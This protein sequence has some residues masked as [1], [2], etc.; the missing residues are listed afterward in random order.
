MM[1]QCSSLVLE[2]QDHLQ[3]MGFLETDPCSG[4]GMM[5]AA[6]NE[7]SRLRMDLSQ[8]ALPRHGYRLALAYI[9][10]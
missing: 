8:D 3:Q 5:R 4:R 6:E 1:I 9:N 10:Y 7:S 2:D